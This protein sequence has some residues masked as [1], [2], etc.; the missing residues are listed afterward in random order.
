MV[1]LGCVVQQGQ[2]TQ[3]QQRQLRWGAHMC[4]RCASDFYVFD[5]QIIVEIQSIE[6]GL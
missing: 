1:R 3:G 2:L 6:T 5:R 4:D